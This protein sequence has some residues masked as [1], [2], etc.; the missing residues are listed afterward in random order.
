M[1]KW[2]TVS[3]QEMADIFGGSVTAAKQTD[4]LN[5]TAEKGGHEFDIHKAYRPKAQNQA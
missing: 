5:Y 4:I 3:L 1:R 2:P